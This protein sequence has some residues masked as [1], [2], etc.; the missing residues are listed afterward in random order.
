VIGD[1]EFR[2]VALALP[3]AEEKPHWERPSFR[4]RNRIFAVL[5]A[6]ECRAVLKLPL[7]ERSALVAEQP[8]VFSAVSGWAEQG[9]TF[10]S[11]ERVDPVELA[12]LVE[13][14][15]RGVAPKRLVAGRG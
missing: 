15:W 4:V 12:E 14:A 6:D 8:D 13:E 2:R 9:W 3:G 10:V 1:E 5:R 7:E 11:L